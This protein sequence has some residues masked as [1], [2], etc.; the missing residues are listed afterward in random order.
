M[1]AH[2]TLVPVD[3]D[4]EDLRAAL[5]ARGL[6]SD[7]ATFFL[8]EGVTQHLHEPGVRATLEALRA[9]PVG[10]RLAF[11]YVRRDFIAGSEL[12]GL[13]ALHRR[14]VVDEGLWHFG[15]QPEQVDEFLRAYGW[16]VD[17]HLGAAEFMARHVAPTGR[18]M[19]VM[20]IERLVIAEK[21]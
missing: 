12:Y 5:T 17:E 2:V 7:A 19:T 3:F 13:A 14:L 6:P 15:L 8:W 21:S 20:P 9:A 4:R 10:S 18:A 1:P 16:R 11:T